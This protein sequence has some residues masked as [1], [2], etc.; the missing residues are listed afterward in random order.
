M[1]DL[2]KV[3]GSQFSSPVKSLSLLCLVDLRLAP[4]KE[5]TK[6]F[7]AGS[8]QQL[9]DCSLEIVLALQSEALAAFLDSSKFTLSSPPSFFNEI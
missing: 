2:M 1:S 6:C 9:R 4:R 8:R 7:S 5:P 3:A